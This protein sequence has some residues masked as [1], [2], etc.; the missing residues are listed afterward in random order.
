MSNINLLPWRE[1]LRQVRNKNFIVMLAITIF[2]SAL[3]M[4][5][6]SQWVSYRVA[7]L[8]MDVAYL[9]SSLKDVNDQIKQIK[10]LKQDKQELLNRINV[11]RSLQL[12]RISLVKLMDMI[13]RVLSNSIYLT[14]I[15][16]SQNNKNVA[17]QNAEDVSQTV[18]SDLSKMVSNP[19]D[20]AEKDPS[21]VS[22]KTQYSIV[23]K[24][25][26]ANNNAI[27][28][29]LKNLSEVSWVSDV[30]LDQVRESAKDS[31][32]AASS[33]EFTLQFFQN[34]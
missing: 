18:L 13:P 11:I 30:Q 29:L 15:T 14:E 20:D 22:D 33:F 7:V 9:D 31:P 16:R 34:I 6:V 25:V 19:I 8:S 21:T 4:F 27:S 3:I 24:G 5:C 1:E 26:A 23:L 2:S 12:E 10:N 28:G 32:Q 17:A